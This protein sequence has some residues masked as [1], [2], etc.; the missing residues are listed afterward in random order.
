MEEFGADK[1]QEAEAEW[2]DLEASEDDDIALV[3]G[4]FRQISQETPTSHN[5]PETPEFIYHPEI[6]YT[7][8]PELQTENLSKTQLPKPQKAYLIGIGLAIALA[9]TSLLSLVLVR[10]EPNN[11][12]VTRVPSPTTKSNPSRSENFQNLDTPQL[13]RIASQ[14]FTQG[15]ITGGIAALEVLLDR[16]A[17]SETKQALAAIS[18]GQM[19]TAEISFLR[20]RLIWQSLNGKSNATEIQKAREFWQ[21][22]VKKQPNS[23]LYRNALGFAYYAENKFNEAIDIW[24]EAIALGEQSQLE[25]LAKP[26]KKQVLNN[27][28]GIALAL[29]RV[30]D[31]QPPVRKQELEQESMKLGSKVLIEAP[32]DFQPENLSQ[33]WMWSKTAIEDWRSFLKEKSRQ[34]IK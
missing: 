2:L 28:A 27:Y 22:S 29:W 4:L 7:E 15:D 30:A 21:N 34:S 14:K 16:N 6:S 5:I 31:T 25:I 13:T 3:S 11:T 32:T 18:L 19:D 20:G 8:K 12:P 26:A 33:D 10:L 9:I 1:K 24:F 17:L 23:V